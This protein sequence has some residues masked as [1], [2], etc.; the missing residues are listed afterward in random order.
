MSIPRPPTSLKVGRAFVIRSG[1]LV[2]G[3]MLALALAKAFALWLIARTLGPEAQGGFSLALT[4]MS[5]G[6]IVLGVG[7]EYAGSFVVGRDPNQ[8]GAA[9]GNMLALAGAA[10]VVS[11]LL[12]YLFA[13]AFPQAIYGYSDNPVLGASMLGLGAVLLQA[14]DGFRAIAV[15]LERFSLISRSNILWGCGWAVAVLSAVALGP[16]GVLPAW[17]L[18]SVIGFGALFLPMIYKRT[19]LVLSR[20]VFRRQISFGART[21]PGSIARA[22]NLRLSLYF[23]AATLSPTEVGIYGV[24]LS[25]AEMFLYIPSAVGQ[26][27]LGRASAQRQ[28][29]GANRLVYKAVLGLGL[30]GT[31]LA[32]VAGEWLLGLVFGDVYAA[33]GTATAILLLA[34][35]IHALGLMKLHEVLGHGDPAAATAV[36]L[37]TL[38]FTAAG[39]FLLVPRFGIIGAALATL[40]AYSAFT[41]YLFAFRQRVRLS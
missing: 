31:L 4:G 11:P 40:V 26:V 13:M 32:A 33:G 16:R 14:N 7:Q 27:M 39:A 3:G 5:L 8:A 24:A 23:I 29:G 2:L 21:L 38:C 1:M 30:A 36:Q 35:T 20:E 10:A 28:D 37:L 41:C 22:V 34:S 25:L 9:M 18:A 17:I 19:N 6:A 15:G 12:G